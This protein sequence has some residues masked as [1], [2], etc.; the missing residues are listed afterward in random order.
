MVA[1]EGMDATEGSNYSKSHG[2]EKRKEAFELIATLSSAWRLRVLL[3]VDQ[4]E[5][6]RLPTTFISE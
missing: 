1:P 4:G 2:L 6:N 3:N 5:R